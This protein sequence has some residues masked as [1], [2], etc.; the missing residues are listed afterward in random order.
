MIELLAPCHNF[1]TLNVAI[2]AGANAVYFG[3]NSL[4]MRMNA[5]NFKISDLKKIVKICRES[6]VKSYLT[7][8][9]IV[10]ENEIKKAEKI[11]KKSK[12]SG[13][14]AIIINDLGLIEILKK[15]KMEFHV[16]TQASVTNSKSC[17]LYKK[18]GAKRVILA[19]EV[20][21]KDLKKIV[22]NSK[23]DLEVFIH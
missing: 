17:N 9:S 2:K 1:S 4:N 6:K 7:L 5:K 3:I 18:L 8:N 19:R 22:K 16:S 13:V 15:N 21:L 23:V 11:I 10:Y 14:N 20:S 12:Q